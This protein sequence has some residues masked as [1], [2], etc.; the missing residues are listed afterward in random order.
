[1]GHSYSGRAFRHSQLL[2]IVG[3]P[4]VDVVS[5]VTGRSNCGFV[6]H[7]L[8]CA[9][10][11][12]TTNGNEHELRTDPRNATSPL[13]L[14]RETPA[15]RVRAPTLVQT[16]V[17]N[18]LFSY[19]DHCCMQISHSAGSSA[20][21][22]GA[23][24]LSMAST[25]AG[26]SRVLRAIRLAASS[27]DHSGHSPVRTT[28]GGRI[29]AAVLVRSWYRQNLAPAATSMGREEHQ[30]ENNGKS[31]F[32]WRARTIRQIE[33]FEAHFH[34]HSF[35]SRTLLRRDS[36]SRSTAKRSWRQA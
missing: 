12:L 33:I 36:E 2:T 4:E 13:E 3:I 5:S 27:G 31:Q 32:T 16:Q 25:S 30:G 7:P 20:V 8:C 24:I 22:R 29:R 26:V 9:A 6:T 14:L 11:R 34:F 35:F 17:A 19:H 18:V 1:M 10:L 23:R 28:L 15:P 21:R